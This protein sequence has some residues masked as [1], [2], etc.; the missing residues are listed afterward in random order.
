MLYMM[1]VLCKLC[2]KR[3]Y[4]YDHYAPPYPSMQLSAYEVM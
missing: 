1:Q 4:N 2:T 3:E